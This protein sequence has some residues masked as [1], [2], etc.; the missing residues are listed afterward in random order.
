MYI[1]PQGKRTNFKV[2]HLLHGNFCLPSYWWLLRTRIVLVVLSFKRFQILVNKLIFFIS[3]FPFLNGIERERE[4][5]SLKTALIH[6][7]A[8]SSENGV[9]MSIHVSMCGSM[10]Y[11][12]NYFCCCCFNVFYTFSDYVCGQRFVTL[13]LHPWA[14]L[15]DLRCPYMP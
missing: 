1:F 7:N 13:R 5:F 15:P 11:D 2:K 6:T 9:R 12:Q 10:E 14:G 3:C 4:L 8:H